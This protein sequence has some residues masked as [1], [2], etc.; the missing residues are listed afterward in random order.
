M[1]A[2][3]A[4]PVRAR[5]GHGARGLQPRRR[6]LVPLPARPGPLAGLPLERGRP[7]GD[8]RRQPAAVPGLRL[9][10]R[11][12]PDP[13]GAHL[14]A[15]RRRGQPRRGRQGVLVVPRLHPHPLLD[16]LALHVPAGRVPVRGAPGGQPRPRPRR[17]RVRAARHRR[18]ST[19][20]AT[21]TSRSTTPRPPPTTSACACGSATPGPD[22]ATLHLLP[23]L[24][25]R[26]RWSWDPAGPAA[27]DR[28]GGRGADRPRGGAG[29]HVAARRR[30]ARGAL[31]PQPEQ[32]RA[33]SGARPA[34]PSPRTG[35][36]TTWCTG[37]PRSTRSATG[38]KA[39]LW[40]RLDVAAGAT[41]EVRL[42]LAPEAGDLGADLGGDPGRPPR[43]GGRLLRRRSPP[44]RRPTRCT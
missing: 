18:S 1:A 8:L 41:A 35:S 20:T 19:R 4:L 22:A 10:E 6:G 24:W 16:A 3:G 37:A 26:N 2:L 9:L 33:R 17:A 12:R 39:A 38:T 25:F 43:G 23:H 13:Q 28:A 29:D 44:P 14:R 5:L 36:T 42:R 21:G 15:D 7:R 27:G 40:Y 11:A 31:L 32:H 34:T 30:R